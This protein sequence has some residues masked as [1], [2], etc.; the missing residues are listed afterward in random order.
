MT[1]INAP[2]FNSAL[3]ALANAGQ[4]VMDIYASN[5]FDTKQKADQSPVT[6]ADIQSSK[7][8]EHHLNQTG[9]PIICEESEI[10]PYEVRTKYKRFWLVDPLDGTKEFI[11]RN[12]EFT[13][14]IGLIEDGQPIW[15]GILI[16]AQN[17][18]YWGGP[19]YGSF[20]ALLNSDISIVHNF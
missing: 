14:N 11:N 9:V 20:K 12:G 2:I 4:K 10:P 15:G 1:H 3:V 5:K 13:I 6:I 8:I 16:P 19:A 17:V 7:I 18:L